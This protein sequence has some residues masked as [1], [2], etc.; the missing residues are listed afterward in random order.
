MSV[1]QIVKDCISSVP[2]ALAAGVVD[3]DSGMLLAIQTVESHPQE[4]IDVLAAATRDLFEGDM[5]TTI[6][7]LFKKARGVTS[8]ERYFKEILISSSH[9]WH[10]FGRLKSMPQ[11][12]VVVV[13]RADVNLG[14]MVVK[15]RDIAANSTV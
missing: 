3:M 10:Y 6:E 1:E 7:D 11:I 5:V 4:V 8:A 9:L 13:T 12:V 15:C 14:L 2:K